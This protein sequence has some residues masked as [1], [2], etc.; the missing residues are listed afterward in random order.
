MRKLSPVLVLLTLVAL[1]VVMSI[2]REEPCPTCPPKQTFAAK[3]IPMEQ[4]LTV[5]GV[6]YPYQLPQPP[7][8]PDGLEPYI[9]A[10]TMLI[11]LT[12]HHQGYIDKLNKALEPH[13]A[14][15]G[16]TLEWLLMHLDTLPDEIRQTVTDNGGG[17]F[18]H[19][20]FW[21][22]MKSAVGE[23][24]LPHGPLAEAIDRSFGS[25]EQ[26]KKRF[27]TSAL[28][29]VGSG[30]TWLCMAPD[31]TLEV[32]TTLNHDT[33][34]RLG[35]YPLLIV[36]V[37]EHAYYLKYQNRRPDFVAAWWNVVDWDRVATRY[38]MASEAMGR[39][40]VD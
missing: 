40:R 10:A 25:F 15:Q 33:P 22:S 17:H 12:K 11:H 19:L 38:Q 16:R 5:Y 1:I 30:W 27:E 20:L 9:D 21:D 23:T 34:L 3:V 35:W 28:S 29:H 2:R 31:G 37:W 13:P 24:N 6:T 32:I 8:P 39:A 36:D 26:F 4:E 14:Y 7:Y 18:N